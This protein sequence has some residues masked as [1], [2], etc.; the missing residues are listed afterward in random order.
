M[1]KAVAMCGHILLTDHKVFLVQSDILINR[2][3]YYFGLFFFFL[4]WKP[5]VANNRF[6]SYILYEHT[7]IEQTLLFWLFVIRD[8]NEKTMNF[9]IVSAFKHTDSISIISLMW[10]WKA[11]IK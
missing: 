6:K 9:Y 10:L 7:L 5:N 4:P 1:K 3:I 8:K 11:L 2:I